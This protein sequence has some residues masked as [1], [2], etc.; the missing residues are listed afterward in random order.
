MKRKNVFALLLSLVVLASCGNA[1]ESQSA[2][3]ENGKIEVT[4]MVGRTVAVDEGAKDRVLCIGAGALR[5]YSY[6]GDINNI[7]AVE[8]ID[9]DVDSNVFASVSRPYY[10]LNREYFS[11]LPS[12]GKGGPKAQQAEPE[13]ILR[14]KPSLI[15]SQYEDVEK[16]DALQEQVGVPVI[17]VKYGSN[18]VF[19]NNVKNS[20]SLLGKVLDKEEKANKLNNYIDSCKNELE[21]NA[22]NIPDSEKKSMY[23]GC[24]GNWGT[25]DIFSTSSNFPLFNVSSIKNAVTGIS[26]SNGKLEKEKLISLDPEII[27][28]DSAGLAN[29][30]TTYESDSETFDSMSAFKNGEIYLEMP[31]NAYYTNLEIALMDSYYLASISY[32][33]VYENYD[34]ESKYDEISNAFLGKPCYDII[35][36][37]KRSYGGFQKITNIK[38]FFENAGQ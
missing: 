36:S 7:V 5:M 19:D 28:L 32:P 8:D 25:Q 30:K 15:I 11:T 31:F 26:L 24:L 17:V 38:E 1:N 4:D 12:C 16:A 35:K 29:F 33:S 27:V 13:L 10:D 22:K 9:R 3:A 6:I 34:L 2:S 37:A 20:F 14:C 18:S 21:D 23:I